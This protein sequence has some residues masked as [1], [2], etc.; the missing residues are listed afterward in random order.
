MEPFVRDGGPD[1]AED[2]LRIKT[3]TWKT[4]YRGLLPQDFLDELRVELREVELWRARFAG[5]AERVVIGEAGGV[6][7]GFSLFGSARDREIPGGEIYA[8]YVL[9]EHWS[10]GLGL[11]LMN[12][13]VA[14]LREMGHAEAGLWVLESN[15]RARR[16]Y[17]RFGFTLSGRV[18]DVEGLPVAAPEV[19]Y[20]LP[21][22]ADG[23]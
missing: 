22:A 12:R 3:E 1:D 23:A 5:A 21:L 8:I 17:E 18:Q 6:S 16:F 10:T 2:V 19:H 15:V 14:R 4:A 7:A 9:S 11:A 13:S 20:R